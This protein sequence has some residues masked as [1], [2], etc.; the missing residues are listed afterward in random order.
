MSRSLI[1][2]IR[3]ANQTRR[4]E[5]SRA[6][7]GAVLAAVLTGTAALAAV[8]AISVVT[9]VVLFVAFPFAYWVSYRRRG[10]DNWHIKLALTA[11]AILALVR[12]LSQLGTV[13]TLDEIRFPLADLFLWV[14]VLHSFDLPA[15]KDLNFSL[16]SSLTLM[17]V[18]GSLS[19]D[20]TYAVFVVLYFLSV[21]ASLYLSH[22]SEIDNDAAAWLRPASTAA[23]A[24]GGWRDVARA[25][26]A[27]ALAAG[28]LFL[29]LPQPSGVQT[30][31][32]PFSLGS[33][34][35]SPAGGGILNPGSEDGAT[36]RSTAAS[37]YAFNESMDLR[38]R[39]DLPDQLVMRVRA[40]APA[41]WK[42]NIF[43]TYDGDAWIGTDDEAFDYTGEA[44]PF[45]YPIPFRSL[46]PRAE[47]TQTFYIEVEQASV[48]FAAG[49]PDRIWYDGTLTVDEL[50]GLRTG[51]TL[52]PGSVYSVVSTRGAAT[53]AELRALPPEAPPEWIERY[54]QLPSDLPPRVAE[55]AERV[56]RGA[57]TDYDKVVAIEDY[58][59]RNYRYSTDSPVPPPGADAVDHFLFETDVGFCEQFASATAVMLRTL[60]IPARV[61]AGYTPGRRNPFTGYYEV[62][63]SDAHAWI[64]VWFPDVGWYEFDPTFD[65][66]PA[67]AQLGD[68]VP[69][70]KVLGFVAEKLNALAPGSIGTIL[71]TA[72]LV[73]LVVV[74]AVGT[75]IAWRKLRPARRRV[76]VT[77]Q[78]LPRGAVARAFRRFEDA[79]ER[80]GAGR[81]PPETAAELLARTSTLDGGVSEVALR[82][83]EKESYGPEPPSEA[84][85][86]RAISEFE[87]L[88]KA[89]EHNR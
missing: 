4:P 75:W 87:R 6:L 47:I 69:L 88:S 83:F 66:P 31:A 3:T 78:G 79:L 19:V 73:A 2:T 84:E 48:I 58:L 70:A 52:S 74:V 61:V 1:E 80:R 44:P 38:V 67:E 59:E 16:G 72:M 36:S 71:K 50:G 62:K 27:V 77:A 40:S 81:S 65:I 57:I 89:A 39:G 17:A 22:R 18:A 46:G 8:H 82:A 20:M 45:F 85:A 54:L 37:Y 11:G 9:L 55:L 32:L 56:T 26:V 33:G 51:G 63:A 14:Q 30:F 7:R 35:G 49:Q 5:D 60:G 24:R 68:V 86:Q 43:D 76:P 12:F 34:F 64:E 25:T 15:R 23:P 13:A 21:V 28:V 53:P 42:G 41:M 29:I 10:E